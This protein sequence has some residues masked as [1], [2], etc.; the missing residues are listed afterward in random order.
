MRT[1]NNKTCF[2]QW[3][4]NVR[5]SECQANALPVRPLRDISIFLLSD[6]LYVWWSVNLISCNRIRFFGEF[7]LVAQSGLSVV[8]DDL[9][10][11]VVVRDWEE[12]M[13]L[14]IV[15]VVPDV[16]VPD[17]VIDLVAAVPGVD[18]LRTSPTNKCKFSEKKCSWSKCMNCSHD[19]NM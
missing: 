15:R 19:Y 5:P 10:V 18:L 7:I 16:D 17:G 1:A 12:P 11:V 2:T 14:L 6:Y 4:A 8:A 9:D 13:G 3:A